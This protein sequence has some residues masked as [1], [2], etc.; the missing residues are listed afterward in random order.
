MLRNNAIRTVSPNIHCQLFVLL[1]KASYFKFYLVFI[2]VVD[3]MYY[4]TAYI[5]ADSVLQSPCSIRYVS[6]IY[7]VYLVSLI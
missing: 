5:F 3:I 4:L 1:S 2:F 6:D 7:P